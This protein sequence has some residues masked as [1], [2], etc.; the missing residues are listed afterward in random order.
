MKAP[1]YKIPHLAMRMIRERT[2]TVSSPHVAGPNDAAAIAHRMIGDRPTEHMIAILLDGQANVTGVVTLAQGGMHT[3]SIR[4]SDVLRAVR[5]GHAC[6]FVLAHNHPSGDPTPSQADVAT[7]AAIRAAAA[8]VGV[9][10]VDHVVVTRDA[11]R[12]T[13]CP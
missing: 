1:S 8:L 12:F 7:T 2:I 11:A 3:M 4:V 10:L 5:A 9:P 6:A 13:S